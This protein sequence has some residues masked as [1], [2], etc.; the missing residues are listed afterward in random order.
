MKLASFDIFDTTLIRKCGKPKNIFFLLAHKLYPHD[1]AKRADFIAWRNKAE[2]IAARNVVG[3]TT[4][5]DIYSSNG[6]TRFNEYTTTQLIDAEKSIESENLTVNPSVKKI[7][8][9]YRKEGKEICFISDMYLDSAFLAQILRREGCLKG[10]ER[11]YVSCEEGAR[12]SSGALFDKVR[13]E[14]RPREWEHYGD[15]PV[16]DIK[17]A[18]EKGIKATLINTSYTESEQQLDK[19]GKEFT[20][21]LSCLAGMQ[22]ATRFACGNNAYTTLAADYVAPAYIPYVQYI[23]KKSQELGV[24]RLYFLS[25]DSYILQK[26]AECNRNEF[27]EIELKYLF[28]S[29]KSLL[30]PY[31]KNPSAEKFIAIQDKQTIVGQQ[32][33]KLLQNLGTNCAELKKEYAITFDYT[34]IGNSKEEA[35]FLEKVFGTTS[36][37]RNR[38]QEIAT[39][40]RAL[41]NRYFEQEGVLDDELTAMVDVGWLGTTRLMINSILKEENRKTTLFFYY[42]VRGDVLNA[43]YGKYYSYNTPQELSTELTTIIENYFSASP[44]PSTIGYR[45]EDNKIIPQFKGGGAYNENEITKANIASAT[46]LAKEVAHAIPQSDSLMKTWCRCATNEILSLKQKDIDLCPLCESE[47]FDGTLFVKRLSSKELL[48]IMLLGGRCTAFDKASVRLTVGYRLFPIVWRI[49]KA[50]GNIRRFLY[51]KLSKRR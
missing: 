48:N 41:L 38:L 32:V 11:V 28:V 12:K 23:L 39:E 7:I 40:K 36:K 8:D 2:G 46:H 16:S 4:I 24:K 27:P 43:S 45:I 30:L 33:E 49:C 5:T 42:G 29:R 22:R 51:L 31:L 17:R 15:H 20:Y 14:L 3:E 35:D 9:N 44:Y 6:A 21:E 1:E 47:L 37:Y 18:K 50:T 25:R 10:S 26:I 19:N 13:N 34:R